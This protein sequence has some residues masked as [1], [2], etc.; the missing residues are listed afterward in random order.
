ML[1]GSGCLLCWPSG[2]VNSPGQ[3]AD[4]LSEQRQ[5][6]SHLFPSSRPN[7]LCCM[8]VT[9]GSRA[10]AVGL[11]GS[12]VTAGADRGRVHMA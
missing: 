3:A 5:H 11:Q 9:M 1:P 8:D 2:Q 12:F 7:W 10:A 4:L 6:L